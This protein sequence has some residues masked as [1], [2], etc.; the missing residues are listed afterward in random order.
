[1]SGQRAP[2]LRRVTWA[3]GS[4]LLLATVTGLAG[5]PA[6]AA[7]D[8]LMART[9]EVRHRPLGDAA[10]IV[11][12]VLSAD[13]TMTLKPHLRVL[14]VQDHAAVL[15]RIESLLRSFDLPPRNVEVTLSLFLGT[16]RPQPEQGQP[17]PKRA[18]I[19]LPELQFMKWT[20]YESLGSRS[21][22]G[23][24]GYP[25]T[26]DLSD[27]Y[28]VSFRVDEVDER[29]GVVKFGTV[30]LQRINTTAEGAERIENLY[31]MA[32]VVETG[33]PH[34]FGAAAGPDAERALFLTVQA[35]LR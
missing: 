33:K 19:D 6:A 20:N 3:V 10:D 12:A 9:F 5:L 11:G 24:E 26:T 14:V 25:V 35:R 31:T 21:V 18:V 23:V 32:M 16:R 29:H 27:D 2:A 7:S 22:N 34:I 8:P 30:S 28:R 13:G 1:M 4:A 17:P 15:D